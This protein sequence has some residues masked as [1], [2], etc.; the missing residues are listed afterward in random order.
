M[1]RK[2]SLSANTIV[3]HHHKLHMEDPSAHASADCA[4]A[5][6]SDVLCR[7]SL[8]LPGGLVSS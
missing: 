2:R 4:A 3:H 5:F 6:I 1:E 7:D 8:S